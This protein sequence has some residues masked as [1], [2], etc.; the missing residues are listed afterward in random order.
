MMSFVVGVFFGVLL[1]E[2][3][4]GKIEKW[5]AMGDDRDDDDC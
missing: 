3:F 4:G 1:W 2:V 5:G